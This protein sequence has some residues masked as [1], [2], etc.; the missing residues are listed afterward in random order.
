MSIGFTVGTIGALAMTRLRPFARV[1]VLAA[2]CLAVAL[3]APPA[4]P[5]DDITADPSETLLGIIET[6]PDRL[7]PQSAPDDPRSADALYAAGMS[8]LQAARFDEARRLFELFVVRDPQHP[9]VPEARRH[10]SELYQLDTTVGPPPPPAETAA[11]PE[12]SIAAAPVARIVATPRSVG[13]R[14]EDSFMLEAGD[15]VFFAA[16]SADLGSRARTV[17]AAQARWLKRNSSLSA[18][19]E[20]H[21]DDPALDGDGLDRLGVERALAVY[22]RLI[23]EGVAPERLAIAPQGKSRPVANCDTPDCAAQNRR[24]VTVLTG[25]R[26]S[27]LPVADPLIGPRRP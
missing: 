19:I 26:L 16:R 11:M 7:V 24:A 17:L 25:Q 3:C 8:E 18:V 4:W 2:G 12:P 5:Q 22:Q 13:G 6:P 27:E 10:L 20:G 14:L 21:S 15:R 9:S 23:E 1:P